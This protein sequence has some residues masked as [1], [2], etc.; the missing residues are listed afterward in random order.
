MEGFI[1]QTTPK[2]IILLSFNERSNYPAVVAECV[3]ERLQIQV[4][5][6]HSSQVQI[7]A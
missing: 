3:Y 2:I 1:S 5:E 6:S 4:A 7:P